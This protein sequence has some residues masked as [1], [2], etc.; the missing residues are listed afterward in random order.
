MKLASGGQCY[1]FGNNFAENLGK[2]FGKKLGKKLGEKSGE[3]I[4]Y[5]TT[6]NK[7]TAGTD[8][9]IFKIFSQKN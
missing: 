3:N 1:N 2:N 9:M 8:V 4:G 7:A 5:S 6:Q